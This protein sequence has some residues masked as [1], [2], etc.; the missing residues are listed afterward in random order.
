MWEVPG[1]C[2]KGPR[3]GQLVSPQ[4]A[5][6]FTSISTGCAHS[7]FLRN[8]E[9]TP[10]QSLIPNSGGG[11]ELW[12]V[13]GAAAKKGSVKSPERWEQPGEGLGRGLPLAER[14]TLSAEC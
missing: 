7:R 4:S 8:A 3:L 10:E 6:G 13:K 1:R 11:G 2:G 5:E 9:S 14:S 12:E